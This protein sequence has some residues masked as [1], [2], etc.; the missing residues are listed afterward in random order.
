MVD[1]VIVGGGPAGLTAGL[2]ASRG[3]LDTVLFE[4]GM[5]G[6]QITTSSEIENYPGQQTVISGMDLMQ[7]WLPQAQ[8]F[9]LRYEQDEITSVSRSG[10]GSF[11]LT[12]ASGKTHNALSVIFATGSV[13]KLAGF[14]GEN[15]FR[16]KGISTCATCDG[17][18]YRGKEV[19][20]IGGGN[21]AIEEAMFLAKMCKKVY[22]IHRRDSFKAA[23]A[24]ITRLNATENIELVLNA[25]PLKTLGDQSGVT[26]IT[27]AFADGTQRD[28]LVPGIFV[29]V[30]RTV[31]NNAIKDANGDFI[32]AVADNGE[33]IVDLNM[34][35]SVKGLFAAG[36]VRI[37]SP[38]Q[39]VCAASDGAIAALGALS[40]VDEL[41]AK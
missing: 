15:E 37:G 2:Y 12:A 28:I 4:V 21:A 26:G 1:L 10:D 41:K 5:P 31:I 18:F 40:F 6:G 25:K 39:V 35:T 7:N 33:V 13:P 3:G 36:D 32:C 9:G 11:T 30:G 17:F 16:G 8:H 24:T 14:E 34:R 27:V 20:V 19:A 29:F 38:K 22:L 23:T